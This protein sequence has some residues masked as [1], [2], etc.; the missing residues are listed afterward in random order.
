MPRY[1]NST[2]IRG[3]RFREWNYFELA[4]DLDDINSSP[5]SILTYSEPR[6]AKHFDAFT[7]LTKH[8]MWNDTI[9]ANCVGKVR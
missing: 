4:Y 5:F 9:R 3:I 8:E 1:F 7:S 6:K 2:N